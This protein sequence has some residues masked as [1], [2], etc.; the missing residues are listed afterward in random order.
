MNK[1][2]RKQT[3]LAEEGRNGDCPGL[4]VMSTVGRVL[5][6]L[7]GFLADGRRGNFKSS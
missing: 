3:G 6:V 7:D 4:G 2:T 1:R 5:A